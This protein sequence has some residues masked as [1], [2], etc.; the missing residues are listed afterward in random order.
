MTQRDN[1]K[2]NLKSIC[3]DRT[4]GAAVDSLFLKLHAVGL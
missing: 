4:M 1:N 3:R 2:A